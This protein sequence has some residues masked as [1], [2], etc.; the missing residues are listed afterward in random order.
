MTISVTE[1]LDAGLLARIVAASKTAVAQDARDSA[2]FAAVGVKSASRL[3]VASDL[4]DAA[5]AA[6]LNHPVIAMAARPKRLFPLQLVRYGIGDGYGRHVDDALMQGLRTDLAVTL[7]LSPPQDYEGGELVL[8][9]TSGE[10][11]YKLPAGAALVYPATFLHRVEPVTA[12]ARLVLV[13][14]IESVIRDAERRELLL[15]LEL[16]RRELFVRSGKDDAFD[17]L[18]RV[19]SNLLRMWSE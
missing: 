4:I 15:D 13:G 12:G 11:A 18:S 14:W 3:V 5:A 2:G 10:Q 17:R 7:F 9:D 8:E 16:A 19:S 6:L 1:V